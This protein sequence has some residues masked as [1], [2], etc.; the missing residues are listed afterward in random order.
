MWHNC[1]VSQLLNELTPPST[2]SI[3]KP[4]FKLALAQLLLS[5]IRHQGGLY[6]R[7]M[8]RLVTVP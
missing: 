6:M 2:K 8:N 1:V 4:F 7:G 5:L 3:Q